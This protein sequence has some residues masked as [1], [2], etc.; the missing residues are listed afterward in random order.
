MQHL[1]RPENVKVKSIW[2]IAQLF[3]LVQ[4][5]DGSFVQQ[6]VP[7]ARFLDTGLGR[8]SKYRLR[9]RYMVD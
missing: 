3:S 8:T 4:Y 9:V 5:S 2:H 1:K 6:L 7:R